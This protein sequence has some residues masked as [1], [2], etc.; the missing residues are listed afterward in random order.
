MIYLLHLCSQMVFLTSFFKTSE[1][2]FIVLPVYDYE[3]KT[4][5]ISGD[6]S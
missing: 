2:F 1:S 3:D 5:Y 4:L 6:K